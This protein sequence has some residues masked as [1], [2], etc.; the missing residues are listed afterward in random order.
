VAR[1]DWYCEDVLSGKLA[2]ERVYEDE[3]VLA[4]HHPKP[5]AE[6]HVVVVP[7]TH[8]AGL[9]DE[10]ALNGNLLSSMIRAIQ[11]TASSLGLLDGRGFYVRANAA[12]PGVTPHMHWHVIGPGAGADW[13]GW[14]SG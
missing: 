13:P 2:V 9:M 6:V 5:V 1:R 3:L 11:Q 10:T 14:D 12:A 4:F 7:K 8:V